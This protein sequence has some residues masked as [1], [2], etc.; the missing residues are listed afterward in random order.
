MRFQDN[1]DKEQNSYL[2]LGKGSG[3]FRNISLGGT[4]K[5]AETVDWAIHHWA[6][7]WDNDA[8]FDNAVVSNVQVITDI[9]C[10]QQEG[11]SF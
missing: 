11:I 3:T 5:L 9:L 7:M 8:H 1:G 10:I 6:R 4:K 2:G